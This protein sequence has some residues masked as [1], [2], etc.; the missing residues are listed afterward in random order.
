MPRY[1]ATA[2]GRHFL[3]NESEAESSRGIRNQRNAIRRDK[4][5][6][7]SDSFLDQEPKM[8]PMRQST[9]LG[10]AICARGCA[11]AA[12]AQAN[13]GAAVNLYLS[14]GPRAGSRWRKY[15]PV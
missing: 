10:S 7:L 9:N 11:A 8:N 1:A 15:L 12:R 2:D 3:I 5:A 4:L 6:I 14:L 13:L